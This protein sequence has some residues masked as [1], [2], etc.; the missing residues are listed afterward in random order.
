MVIGFM[1]VI[2]SALKDTLS[3]ENLIV[4]TCTQLLPLLDSLVRSGL[5]LHGTMKASL[6]LL[7]IKM[8]RL[9]PLRLA[10]T[11]T[12]TEKETGMVTVDSAAGT[13]VTSTL[14]LKLLLTSLFKLSEL[15]LPTP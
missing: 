7:R 2:I 13:M 9:S 11:N 14:I 5:L 1:E 8:D 10:K 3:G 15:R 6:S 12:I 4:A